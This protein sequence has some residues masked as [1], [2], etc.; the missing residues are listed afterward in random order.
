YDEAIRYIQAQ[1]EHAQEL[2]AFISSRFS[3]PTLC[4]LLLGKAARA[5]EK[6]VE[7]SFDPACRVDKP[8]LPLLESE[9]ISI[10]G[11]LLD[12]AIE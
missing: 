11:N 10:I 7:L 8:F 5:R 3:S 4:G 9:L 1:S 6:G 2:L 12:N